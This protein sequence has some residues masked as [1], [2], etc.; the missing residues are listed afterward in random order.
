MAIRALDL[1]HDWQWGMNR[2]SYVVDA[3]E[4]A[5][6]LETRLLSFYNDCFFAAQEGIDWF[7]LLDYNNQTKIEYDVQEV[8][9]NTPGVVAIN[10]VDAVLGA[11]RQLKIQYDIDTIFTSGYQ[12]EFTPLYT[13]TNTQ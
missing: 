3:K 4:I 10:S 7:N 9:K 2:N 1:N 5:E 13:S 6:N 8:I 11:N 12:G